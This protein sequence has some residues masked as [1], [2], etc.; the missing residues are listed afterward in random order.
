MV[1]DRGWSRERRTA[2]KIPPNVLFG[3]ERA[4]TAQTG[5]TR[6]KRDFGLGGGNK[7]KF[8]NASAANLPPKSKSSLHSKLG[9]ISRLTTMGGRAPL[10]KAPSGGLGFSAG[11]IGS[12]NVDGFGKF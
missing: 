12:M 10:F 3:L 8:G 9:G 2:A 5:T 4:D 1:Q 11:D 7:T 6:A